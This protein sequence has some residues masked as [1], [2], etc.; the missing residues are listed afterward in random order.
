MGS[1]SAGS[2]AQP[3]LHDPSLDHSSP[4]EPFCPFISPGGLNHG[5]AL[6]PIFNI[7]KNVANTFLLKKRRLR[8]SGRPHQAKAPRND[9]SPEE[10]RL[11]QLGRP[12]QA[13]YMSKTDCFPYVFHII[14]YHFHMSFLIYHIFFDVYG[15]SRI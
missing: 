12:H 3:C 10:R 7:N 2:L 9:L 4:A 8:Q 15:K 6:E 13:Y 1:I 11:R 14:S 5:T